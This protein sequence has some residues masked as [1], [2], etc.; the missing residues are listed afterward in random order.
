MAE[1]RAC[2]KQRAFGVENA[3]VDGRYRTARL[4][5]KCQRA[6]RAQRVETFLKRGL[7]H[8][9][10]NHVHTAAAGEA[11]GFDVEFLL[12]I[13]DGFVGPR[14]P[15][16][17]RLLRGG[18]SAKDAGADILR[19]LH[20]QSACAARG[21]MHQAGVPGFERKRGVREIV[22]RHA[23]QHGGGRHFEIHMSGYFHQLGGGHHGVLGVGSA[24]H[25]I[26]HTVAWR[27]FGDAF[28]H[29]L[30]GAGA[31]TADSDREV[32]FVQAGT[33]ISVDE[34]DVAGGEANQRLPGTRLRHR[35]ID[36]LQTL[37]TAWDGDLNSFHNS[38]SA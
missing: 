21:S 3:R 36:Q 17:P 20:D 5:E 14:F 35:D 10:V 38:V 24:C 22:G 12:G 6:A 16:D 34:V 9:I 15:R 13:E 1:T 30:H 33:K 26:G 11:P 7:A 37:R 4:T 27:N 19:H 31:F 23:L 29:R 2:Q 32:G 25:R 18:N 28:A 8:G